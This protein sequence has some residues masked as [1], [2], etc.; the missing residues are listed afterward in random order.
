MA[1]LKCS[2]CCF[3]NVLKSDL[4]QLI[5]SCHPWLLES[6]LNKKN[7]KKLQMNFVL[8]HRISNVMSY[9]D[10]LDMHLL[11]NLVNL[12]HLQIYL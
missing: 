1:Q 4:S 7:I 10:D 6:V 11:T 12:K 8:Q 9:P 2:Q 3:T 5:A